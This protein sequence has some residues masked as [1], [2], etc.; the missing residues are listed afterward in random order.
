MESFSRF[1]WTSTSQSYGVRN[2]HD[3]GDHPLPKGLPA[4]PRPGFQLSRSN[5]DVRLHTHR[6]DNLT[7]RNPDDIAEHLC[8]LA[9]DLYAV[10]RPQECLTWLKARTGADVANLHRFLDV[11]DHI[12][13]WVQKSIVTYD[14]P[15]R[16]ADTLDFWICVAEKCRSLRNF[17]SF[18]AIMTGLSNVVLSLR[19]TWA[20]CSRKQSF[21]VLA[22]TYDSS[23]GFG[24]LI[25]IM[26]TANEPCVPFIRAYLTNI[27]EAE[28]E[29]PDDISPCSVRKTAVGL[30]I[31]RRMID[32]TLSAMMRFQFPSYT[33]RVLSSTRKFVDE[34]LRGAGSTTST[35]IEARSRELAELDFGA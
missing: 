22:K 23:N 12:A 34:Q 30:L 14:N 33:F 26:G 8:V 17:D 11:H 9:H 13:A 29:C 6:E 32:D 21:D 27:T 1:K 2:L 4:S 28:K 19:S 24:K 20:R 35:W 31:K 10:I 25:A 7:I 18:G 3:I 5:T 16:R 15:G